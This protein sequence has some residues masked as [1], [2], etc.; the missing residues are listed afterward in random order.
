LFAPRVEPKQ[1]TREALLKAPRAGERPQRVER[2]IGGDLAL[3][4]EVHVDARVEILLHEAKW[5]DEG[6]ATRALRLRG[7]GL[8]SLSLR[9]TGRCGNAGVDIGGRR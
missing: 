5:I 6:V 1:L 7:H 2:R 3:V 4:E 9:G 8:D